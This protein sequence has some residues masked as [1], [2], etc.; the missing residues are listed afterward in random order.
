MKPPKFKQKTLSLAILAILS[1]HAYANPMGASVV[2]GNV[3]IQQA[4][5]ALNITNSPNSIINW[6][7]FNI[8]S[9]EVTRFIQQSASSAVLNRVTGQDPSS[10]LGALQSNGRVFLINPNGIVFGAGSRLDVAG[11][12][13]STHGMSDADFAAGKLN[14]SGSSTASVINQG[15]IETS[16][17]GRV[18]LLA[19]DVQN[20]GLIHTPQGEVWLVAGKAHPLMCG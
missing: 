18:Y 11:L 20:S 6:Q 17:G 10:I 4:G 2:A 1:G 5:N 15:V 7:Q 8:A 16:T 12:I 19:Q 3:T 13:A 14:F 9:G